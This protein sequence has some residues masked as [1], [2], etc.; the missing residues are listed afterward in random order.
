MKC[1]KSD[2][3]EGNL[4]SFEGGH[5]YSKILKKTNTPHLCSLKFIAALIEQLGATKLRVLV[6]AMETC[7]TLSGQSQKWLGGI[8]LCY[9]F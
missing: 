4:N 5:D 7:L 8:I 9:C 6:T 1:F 2:K 3:S